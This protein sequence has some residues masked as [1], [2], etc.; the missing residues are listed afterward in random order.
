MPDGLIFNQAATILNQISA[1]VQGRTASSTVRDL[2]DFVSVAQT[3]LAAG[4]EAVTNSISALISRTIF[5][6]RPYAGKYDLI[7]RTAEEFGFFERKLTPIFYDSAS[8]LPEYNA[9]P[10]DGQSVDQWKI[11]RPKTMQT[12]FTKANMW[13]L[14]EPTIFEDQLN[15]AFRS[16]EELLQFMAMQATA[17]QNEI[18]QH[19]EAAAIACITN[20]IGAT[21]NRLNANV[22]KLLTEYND[23]T[24]LALTA[25]TVYQP[26]NW[27][28]FVGYYVKRIMDVS[29]SMANRSSMWHMSP[30]GTTVL[31]HTPKAEQRMLMLSTFN[32][33]VTHMALPFAYNENFLKVVPNAIVP[34]WQNARVPSDVNVTPAQ[35]STTGSIETGAAARLTNVVAVLFDKDA[36]FFNIMKRSTRR[37]PINAAADYSNIFHNMVERWAND[38][39]ENFVVFSMS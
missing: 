33:S 18:T 26:D 25:E 30:T 5:S 27:P 12:M 38:Q 20:M 4:T 31:R 16:P 14:Q 22:I 9:L 7:Q 3:T 28:G 36:L 17:V 19:G 10:A 1:D 13:Q 2:S 35:M 24:G 6:E 23:L 11:K 34:Y 37:T 39:T 8:D 15:A 32:N 29:D 21:N